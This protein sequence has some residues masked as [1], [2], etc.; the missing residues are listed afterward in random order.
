MA[1]NVQDNVKGF[2]SFMIRA[3]LLRKLHQKNVIF[4]ADSNA[5]LAAGNKTKNSHFHGRLLN[6]AIDGMHLAVFTCQ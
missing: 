4:I 6:C 5:E 3:H 1:K 2:H